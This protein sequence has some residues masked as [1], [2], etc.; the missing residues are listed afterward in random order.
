MIFK[1]LTAYN[2]YSKH[3]NKFFDLNFATQ[4]LAGLVHYIDDFEVAIPEDKA[5]VLNKEKKRLDLLLNCNQHSRDLISNYD[6][7]NDTNL[8]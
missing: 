7:G 2:Q 1:K 8:F 5:I 3:Y 6:S 4:M